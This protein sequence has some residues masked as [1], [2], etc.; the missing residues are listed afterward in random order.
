[1]ANYP[2]LDDCSGVWTLKEVNNAVMG[3]YWRN[4]GS[5]GIFGG[6]YTP[7]A[8]VNVIEFI[9]M[10]STGDVTDFGDLSGIRQ[11][12]HNGNVSSFTRNTFAGGYHGGSVS[13]QIDYITIMS[14]GNSADFGNLSIATGGEP[15]GMSSST[16]GLYGT[17]AIS[18]SP[19]ETNTISFITMASAGNVV[20][21]G[22]ATVARFSATG[23]SNPTR[24][25]MAGG[26]TPSKQN[27]I[28][29]VEIATTGNATD[30][31]DLSVG[32]TGSFGC[33]S[34]TVGLIA[35]G[36]NGGSSDIIEKIIISSKGNSQDFGDLVAVRNKG[37]GTTNSRKAIF[38]GGNPA[39]NV[40]EE[41]LYTTEGFTTDFGDLSAGKAGLGAG[42]N[43]HGGLNEGYQGTRIAP[44]PTGLGV[45]QRALRLGGTNNSFTSQTDIDFF[46]IS[47]T[48]NASRFGDLNTATST[49]ARGS[50]G[51]IALTA[52]DISASANHIS[53]IL[54][55]SEGNA[56]DFGDIT[57]ARGRVGG[58]SN[59]T[60]AIFGGGENPS[61]SDVID[62]ITIATI[63]NATDFGNLGA[64]RANVGAIANSTRLVFAGGEEGSLDYKNTIEY[65]TIGS[66]GN[67]SDFGDLTVARGWNTGLG[68]ATRGVFP[69]GYTFDG[70]S[71][72]YN[73][74]DYITIGSTGNATDFGD[75]TE[76]RRTGGTSNNTR[77]VMSGGNKADDTGSVTIDYITIASTG[78][79]T[80]FGDLTEVR[81]LNATASNGHGGLS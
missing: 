3:G 43:A 24:G 50:N 67:A 36:A 42:S 35:G 47:T 76:A 18:P 81:M 60:R 71:T 58:N 1:M 74:I 32:K 27:T 29:F 45:G 31:G 51:T 70:S 23:L 49:E 7:S 63:G 15:A 77:G 25:I 53:S 61:K 72:Y 20:D 59:N 48:G 79:A 44:I 28:D 52:S 39:T 38:A 66:T 65:V 17:G 6:G 10:A 33:A 2:Q 37:I 22:D 69:G 16:R 9:T 54:F 19:G 5:R 40:I 21:F 80:D 46:N 13:N 57:V 73:T 4:A 62:Y 11:N 68:S 12:S 75:L 30:F 14:T 64:A 34:S 56:S 41:I 55:A 26:G 78:D 8:A